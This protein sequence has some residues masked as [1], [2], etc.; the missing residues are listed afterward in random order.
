MEVSGSA[1][2]C[3]SWRLAPAGGFQ[4]KRQRFVI[5][6]PR[7]SRILSGG[8]RGGRELY[9]P[10]LLDL[11]HAGALGSPGLNEAFV[12]GIDLDRVL[13]PHPTAWKVLRHEDRQAE[14]RLGLAWGSGTAA[15]VAGPNHAVAWW[16]P[17][18]G[19][20]WGRVLGRCNA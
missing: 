16:F 19:R 5:V 7:C 17:S 9:S 6:N 10:L 11:E 12:V 4:W 18:R 14:H 20:S 1:M 3:H 15:L 13:Q 2:R 8:P